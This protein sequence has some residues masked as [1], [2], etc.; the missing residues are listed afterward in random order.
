[1]KGIVF[2][3]FLELLE[4]R[5]SFELVDDILSDACPPSGGAYTA[6]GTYPHS[7]MVALISAL[8]VR[9]N[10][11]LADVLKDFGSYLFGRFAN[12]HPKFLQ[13]KNDAFAVLASI[14]GI[15]HAEVLKLY[16]DAELPRF[17]VEVHTPDQLVLIYES[18]RQMQ[19]LADGLIQGCLSHFST[20]AHVLR[21]TLHTDTGPRERFTLTRKA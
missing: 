13:G 15:I 17:E 21:E 12:S 10:L 4:E 11:A 2:T 8:C 19:D 9:K 1:M 16:P 20:D 18:A 6:V 5:Y 14:E 7:E 3:E